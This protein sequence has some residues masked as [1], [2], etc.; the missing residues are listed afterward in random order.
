MTFIPHPD[1]TPLNLT[2]AVVTVS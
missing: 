1:T 2:C